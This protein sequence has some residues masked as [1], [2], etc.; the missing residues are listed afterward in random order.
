MNA[1]TPAIEFRNVV[2]SFGENVALN[3]VSF[4]LNHGEMILLT[5]VS[6]S[7]KSVLLRVAMG[8]LKPDSGQILIEGQEIQQLDESELI[9]LRGGRWEWS[10]RKSRSSPD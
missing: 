9:T 4:S 5:G 10:F 7:G 6:A 8:L 3:D 1:Q 2:L